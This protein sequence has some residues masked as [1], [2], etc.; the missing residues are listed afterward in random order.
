MPRV[1]LASAAYDH[2]IRL[3]DAPTGVCYRTIQYADHVRC[4]AAVLR[5]ACWF[6][7]CVLFFFLC[8]VGLLTARRLCCVCA[9]RAKADFFSLRFCFAFCCCLCDDSHFASRARLSHKRTL[10]ALFLSYSLRTLPPRPPLS[11]ALPRSLA[12]LN[13]PLPTLTASNTGAAGEQAGNFARQAVLGCG[14]QSAHPAV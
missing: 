7:D 11:F 8:V 13:K 1:I 14:R 4:A 3:W 9:C 10:V 5:L 2:T 6:C 12:P